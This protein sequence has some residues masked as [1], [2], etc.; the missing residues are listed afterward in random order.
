[1]E[2]IVDTLAEALRTLLILGGGAL[3]A[4][5]VG[6]I[7]P[8]AGIIT[9]GVLTMAAGILETLSEPGGEDGGDG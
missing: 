4:W 7:Y 1:M 8:P 2:K 9:A 6:L 3:I 5:G